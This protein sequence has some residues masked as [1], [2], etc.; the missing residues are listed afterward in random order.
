MGKYYN[1]KRA[2]APEYKVGDFVL[3][4]GRNIKTRRP[5]KKLEL[6]LYGPYQVK[7]RIGKNSYELNL[8]PRLRIHPVFHVVLLEPYHENAIPGREV[9]PEPEVIEGEAEWIVE[10]ILAVK[11]LGDSS[12][13]YLVKWKGW[14]ATEATWEPY[15]NLMHCPERLKDFYKRHPKEPRDPAFKPKGR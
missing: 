13:E 7:R 14:D 3:L 1:E 9:R 11:Q 5:V 10:E 8:P 12:C 2:K 4:D 15:T 6:K